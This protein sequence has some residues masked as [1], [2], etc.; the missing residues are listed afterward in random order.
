MERIAFAVTSAFVF[1]VTFA[2]A[3]AAESHPVQTTGTTATTGA[4]TTTAV[5]A[6]PSTG[7]GATAD[8]TLALALVGLAALFALLALI[9]S[10]RQA[11]V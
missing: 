7:I 2:A 10:S 5:T 1:T 6:V 9:T 3:V 8:P 4:T 11:Q